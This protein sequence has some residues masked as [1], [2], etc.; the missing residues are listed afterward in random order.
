MTVFNDINFREDTFKHLKSDIFLSKCLTLS[1][2]IYEDSSAIYGFQDLFKRDN[3]VCSTFKITAVI[4]IL[5]L[6]EMF[7]QNLLFIQGFA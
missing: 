1:R 3:A 5:Y 6:V 4:V 7:I 2:R